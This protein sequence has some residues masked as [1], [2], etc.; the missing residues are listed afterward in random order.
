M[1]LC[2]SVVCSR[3][4][5]VASTASP[6][7]QTGKTLLQV[8]RGAWEDFWLG[9]VHPQTLDALDRRAVAIEL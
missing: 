8:Q 4:P 3:G 1:T 9:L 2:L 7:P 6:S 5:T